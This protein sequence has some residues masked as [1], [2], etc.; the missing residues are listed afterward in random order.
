MQNSRSTTNHGFVGSFNLFVLGL[1]PGVNNI[2]YFIWEHN[3]WLNIICLKSSMLYEKICPLGLLWAFPS[4]I[5]INELF[6]QLKVPKGTENGISNH[7]RAWTNWVVVVAQVVQ[8]IDGWLKGQELKFYWTVWLWINKII[9][10]I[11]LHSFNSL[12]S[13]RS[14]IGKSKFKAS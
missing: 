9:G 13:R 8:Q 11:L 12:R 6:L 5:I 3:A 1:N 10:M 2:F 4:E 14:L 7:D